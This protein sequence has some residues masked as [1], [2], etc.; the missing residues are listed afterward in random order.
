[1]PDGLPQLARKVR[2]I[3]NPPFLYYEREGPAYALTLARRNGYRWY[4]KLM[5]FKRLESIMA[6]RAFGIP[7]SSIALHFLTVKTRWKQE[8]IFCMTSWTTLET[9]DYRNYV[10]QQKKPHYHVYSK[11][12]FITGA[13]IWSNKRSLGRKL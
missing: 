6:Y 12:P 13:K 11:Q 8:R 5:S 4:G 7:I 1:M 3:S 10:H 9:R 2:Y